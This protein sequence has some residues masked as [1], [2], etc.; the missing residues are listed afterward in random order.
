MASKAQLR[1]AHHQIS[2][3]MAGSGAADLPV[4]TCYVDAT[5]HTVVVGMPHSALPSAPDLRDTLDIDPDVPLTFVAAE[6][7]VRHAG[8]RQPNS[9][10]VGGL[11]I[12]TDGEGT[13]TVV[14]NM[15]GSK[16]FLTAGHVVGKTGVPVFQPYESNDYNYFAGT[17]S[18][19]SDVDG[20]TTDCAFV[21]SP[22]DLGVRQIWKA[23]DAYYQITDTG[24]PAVGAKVYMQGSQKPDEQSGVVAQTGVTVT[25][26]DGTTK[27]N[28]CFGTYTGIPGDSGAPVYAKTG[29]GDQDVTLLGMHIG[30]QSVDLRGILDDVSPPTGQGGDYSIFTPW[31]SIAN[32]LQVILDI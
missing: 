30:G 14:G 18:K 16:G 7:A 15:N 11:L 28:Q 24:D 4:H 20:G 17:A 32:D 31:N 1:A 25:F 10:L 26:D 21:E 8:K 13:L 29:G 22:S 12:S 6:P 27:V 5:A 2:R 23:A 19:V 9:P 3:H